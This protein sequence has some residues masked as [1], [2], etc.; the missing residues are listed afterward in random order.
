MTMKDIAALAGVSVS[1]V[2]RVI[3]SVDNSFGSEE[4][5]NRVWEAI[6]QT[7]YV[8]DTVARS[9]RKKTG[10]AS[11]PI[12]KTL[13]LVF[14]RSKE[15]SDNPFFSQVARAAEQQALQL[16]Y[17]VTSTYSIF[18]IHDQHTLRN[19]TNNLV[20]GAI[21]LGRF[22]SATRKFFERHYKKNIVYVG[23]NAV[24]AEWDQVICDGYDI[25]QTVMKYLFQLGHVQIGYIGETLKEVRYLGYK[26]ILEQNKLEPNSAHICDSPQ[27]GAGGYAGANKLLTNGATLPSAVFCAN[28][29]CAI[30][31]MRRFTEAGLRI[32]EDLTV[33]SIDNVEL[34]Q[35]VSPMLTTVDVPKFEL[36]SEAVKL[37]V[38]RLEKGH[39][40]PIKMVLP[41]NLLIRESSAPYHSKQ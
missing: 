4:V 8:P 3:N 25:A 22:D 9:L 41:H 24:E 31:A 21:V 38:D 13:T 35:Y 16:G 12:S 15:P 11:K 36:G 29:I 27:T 17:V 34:A 14:G 20:A 1:T 33:V 30:G 2:S 18:D 28:D 5:R 7:G 32:P 10:K 26:E 40:L 6:R 39:R 19:V 37:L 23:L